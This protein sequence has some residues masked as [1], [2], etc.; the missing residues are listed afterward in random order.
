MKTRSVWLINGETK[1]KSQSESHTSAHTTTTKEMND[2]QY[3][4]GCGAKGTCSIN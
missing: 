4:G 3:W 1:L 2:I